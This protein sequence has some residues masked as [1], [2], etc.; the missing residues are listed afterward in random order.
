[1]QDLLYLH[2]LGICDISI[3]ATTDV[4]SRAYVCLRIERCILHHILHSEGVWD[5]SE[6]HCDWLPHLSKIVYRFA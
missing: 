2:Y 1:M 3:G 5:H 6:G 4:S